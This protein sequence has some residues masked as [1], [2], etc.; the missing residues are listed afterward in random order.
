[1]RCARW[2][3][4]VAFF[5]AQAAS[6]QGA[7]NLDNATCLGCHGTP[8]FAA[9]RAGGQTRPLFV[10]PDRF[11]ESVHGKASVRCVDCHTSITELPHKSA[12]KTAAEW[13][14]T[15]LAIAKNCIACHA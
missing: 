10:A 9:A 7:A 5:W 4:A 12:S 2:R 11:A 15:R 6:A 8:G 14:K 1:M 3:L 13:D